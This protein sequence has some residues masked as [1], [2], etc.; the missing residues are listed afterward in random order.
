M[1]WL[2]LPVATAK[3]A[4]VLRPGGRLCL[5][6]NAGS[7]PDDLSDALAEVYARVLPSPVHAVFR[8]YAANL[9][10]QEVRVGLGGRRHR[11]CS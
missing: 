10:G 11:R 5:I 8:G 3:A 7:H 1:D 2:D 9:N 4:S 6:W